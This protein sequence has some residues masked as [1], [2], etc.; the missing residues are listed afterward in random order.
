MGAGSS[1]A[2]E[3]QRS[4]TSSSSLSDRTFVLASDDTDSYQI[5]WKP[6]SSA[7]EDSGYSVTQI[8]PVTGSDVTSTETININSI[9]IASVLYEFDTTNTVTATFDGNFLSKGAGD[10]YFS[11]NLNVS[12]AAGSTVDGGTTLAGFLQAAN[13]IDYLRTVA[14]NFLTGA[15]VDIIA[16]A[17][18]GTTDIDNRYITLTNTAGTQQLLQGL[19]FTAP[20][21]ESLSTS[22]SGTATVNLVTKTP[23]SYTHLTLPTI[24]RV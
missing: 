2:N 23:V 7:T 19:I 21:A 18:A 10:I 11:M 1:D 6:N 24:L 15:D 4:I 9:P 5:Y 12:G 16:P 22:V 3:V 13:S 14:H 17:G 8:G 20:A